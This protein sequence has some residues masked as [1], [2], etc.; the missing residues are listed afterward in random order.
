M[1]VTV[2]PGATITVYSSLYTTGSGNHPTTAK[3]ALAANLKVFDRHIVGARDANQNHYGSTWNS[4]TGLVANASI[5]APV[6]VNIGGGPANQYTIT[7]PANGKYLVI[8]QSMVSSDK[9]GGG[10]CTIYTGSK[11]GLH[12]DVDGN[13]NDDEEDDGSCQSA[14]LKFHAVLK[15]NNGKVK[16]GAT[17]QQHGSLMLMISPASLEFS[18][19]V[20]LMPVVYESVEGDWGVSVSADPPYGFYAEPNTELS[21]FVT[22][23]VISSCQF[24]ITDTGSEW[25][26]TQL[27]HNISH[28]GENRTAYSRPQM[29]NLRTNVPTAVNISPNPATDIINVSLSNFEGSA[30]IYISNV[31]GQRMMAKE[32]HLAGGRSATMDVSKLVPG[33]YMVTAENAAGKATGRLI[34]NQK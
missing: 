19:S 14:I 12:D 10:T 15:D 31:N 2:T 9:C 4:A 6:L 21:T 23:S 30:T 18:D 11:V 17:Q 25:T 26:N 22:D 20:E 33:T 27:T 1:P 7:V 28:K 24:T 32:V 13:D 5:S 3:S 16:E 34:K 8:G 29:I